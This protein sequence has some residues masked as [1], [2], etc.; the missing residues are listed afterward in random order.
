MCNNREVKKRTRRHVRKRAQTVLLKRLL[1][2]GKKERKRVEFLTG[3]TLVLFIILTVGVFW[4]SSFQ[5]KLLRSPNVAAV[6]SAVLVQLANSDRS[7]NGLGDLTINPVLVA[8]AQAKANDMASIGYFAHISPQGLD[9]WHWFKQ[10]G[11]SFDYAGEN[12]A[13]DFSDSSDVNT[14]WMN[15]PTHR[16]NILDP[17]YTEIG[18]AEAQGMYQGHPTTFVVQE[19]GTPSGGAKQQPVAVSSVPENPSA[20]ATASTKPA[21]SEPTVLGTSAAEQKPA[22]KPAEPVAAKPSPI[23]TT[24]PAAAAHLAQEQQGQGIPVW[25]YLVSFPKATTHAV[26]YLL[27][28]IIIIALFFDTGLQLKEHHKRKARHAAYALA[29]VCVCF[30]MADY[31]FFAK[32]VLAALAATLGS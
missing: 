27:S 12:L 32:P 7:Q 18:I 14:A 22:P 10:V 8:A 28:L 9:P 26:Y 17:H 24:S 2:K 21:Q 19:F 11:Y 5:Q 30:V 20:L 31:L 4:L 23:A 25:G 29:V 15:S 6:V 16:E 1:P 13:V 3:A